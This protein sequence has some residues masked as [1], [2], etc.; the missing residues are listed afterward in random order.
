[1]SLGALQRALDVT[2]HAGDAGHE[3][4]RSRFAEAAAAAAAPQAGYEAEAG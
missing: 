4:Q 3:A 1:V 2:R